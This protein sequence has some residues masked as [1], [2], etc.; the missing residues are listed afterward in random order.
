M[1]NIK[2]YQKQRVSALFLKTPSCCTL[3]CL[4]TGWLLVLTSSCHVCLNS[5]EMLWLDWRP[6][7]EWR[8]KQ[9]HGFGWFWVPTRSE[10]KL[11]LEKE[12]LDS[13]LKSVST[14]SPASV[15]NL[16][17][18][19]LEI[20]SS[21]PTLIGQLPPEIKNI[22]TSSENPKFQNCNSPLNLA[23]DVHYGFPLPTNPETFKRIMKSYCSFTKNEVFH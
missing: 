9:F 3:G 15:L 7:N 18:W 5:H 13:V 12:N 19:I 1:S 11:L 17:M 14:W 23:G 10:K 8:R 22:L 20:Y 2:T 6:A 16:K 21:P 4:L